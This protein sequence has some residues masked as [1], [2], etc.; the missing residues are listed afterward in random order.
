MNPAAGVASQKGAA[1]EIGGESED[2]QMQSDDPYAGMKEGLEEQIRERAACW[3]TLC[4]C[5]RAQA[6]FEYPVSRPIILVSSLLRAVSELLEVL[7]Q[8]ESRNG[9]LVQEVVF[10]ESYLCGNL[11]IRSGLVLLQHE[12]YQNLHS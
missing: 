4:A 11:V 1:G 5:T 9:V 8:I 2:E 3:R 6:P 10:H 7:R 12:L